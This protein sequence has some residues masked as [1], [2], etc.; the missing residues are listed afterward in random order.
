QTQARGADAAD[1]AVK[2]AESEM[3]EEVEVQYLR[4]F[5]AK[6]MEQIAHASE[7]ELAEE[8]TVTEARVKAGTLTQA[9]LLRVKVAQANASQQAI[10]ARTRVVV[11]RAG[12]LSDIG[13]PPDDTGVEF[14][15]PT[16]LLEAAPSKTPAVESAPEGRPEI[17]QARLTAEAAE[18]EARS[19]TFGLFP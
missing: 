19:R 10:A 13:L 15:E 12:L 9:D 4:M 17:E 18:H 2:V 7:A 14:V 6:T 1:A 5:E 16:A 8:V 3:R 11:A